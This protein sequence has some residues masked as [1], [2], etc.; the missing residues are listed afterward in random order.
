MKTADFTG[1]LTPNGEIAVPPEIACRVP[2][3]EQIQVRLH[4]GIP[5]DDI[6]WRAAGRRQFETAYDADDSV[7]ELLIN[8]APPR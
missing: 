7:Y 6:A 1:E 2:P 4:W 8:D 3:G 5:E